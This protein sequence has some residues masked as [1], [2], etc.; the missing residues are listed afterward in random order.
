MNRRYT[1]KINIGNITNKEIVTTF[2]LNFLIV[3]LSKLLRFM[4][5]GYLVK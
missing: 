3:A 2:I 1:A 5:L 4:G